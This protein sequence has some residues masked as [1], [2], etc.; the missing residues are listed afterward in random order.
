MMLDPMVVWYEIVK[1]PCFDINDVAYGNDECI[2][3][4]Y[5]RLGLLVNNKWI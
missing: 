2:D 1:V 3:K 5:A 4:S